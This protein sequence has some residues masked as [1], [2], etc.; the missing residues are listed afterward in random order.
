MANIR[1]D[2]KERFTEQAPY[3]VPY[4]ALH[5]ASVRKKVARLLLNR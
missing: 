2:Q 5:I 3:T 4:K 1:L